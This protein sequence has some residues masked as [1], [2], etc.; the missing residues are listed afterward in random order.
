MGQSWLFR[1]RREDL[2]PD[3]FMHYLRIED[4]QAGSLWSSGRKPVLGA[5]FGAKGRGF[6][7]S[8][9]PEETPRGYRGR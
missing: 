1:G 8:Q 7:V 5:G 9:G 3:R 6:G 4:I 2:F